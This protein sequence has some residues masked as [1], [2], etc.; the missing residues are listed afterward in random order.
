MYKQCIR[1]AELSNFL[2]N[3]PKKPFLSSVFGAFALRLIWRRNPNLTHTATIGQ[4][5]QLRLNAADYM[6]THIYM[7]NI[8]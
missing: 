4:L 6:F 2:P 3:S 1:N 5:L 7:T 8:R